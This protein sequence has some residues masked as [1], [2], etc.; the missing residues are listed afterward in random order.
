[1]SEGSTWGLVV[2]FVIVAFVVYLVKK[3]QFN[4]SEG[5]SVIDE[6]NQLLDPDTLKVV[7]DNDTILDKLCNDRLDHLTYLFRHGD[8][9]FVIVYNYDC[10]AISPETDRRRKIKISIEAMSQI[11]SKHKHNIDIM[12]FFTDIDRYVRFKQWK[13][14]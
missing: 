4:N 5:L 7:W 14:Y 11:V 2:G 3:T 10:Y 12:E 9:D 6:L 13:K 8:I 1:M